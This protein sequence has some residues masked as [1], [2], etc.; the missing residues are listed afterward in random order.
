M[1]NAGI[2][3]GLGDAEMEFEWDLAKAESNLKKHG[4]SFAEAMAIFGDPLEVTISDPAHQRPGGLAQR[5]EEV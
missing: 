4:V 2:V 3:C 5:A 1:P